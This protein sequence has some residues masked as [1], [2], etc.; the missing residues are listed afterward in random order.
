[1]LQ[2][3]LSCTDP[4]P[5]VVLVG[6]GSHAPRE[7]IMIWISMAAL[8]HRSSQTAILGTVPALG[9]G[10]PIAVSTRSLHGPVTGRSSGW[11]PTL[12]VGSFSTTDY[13]DRKP[14]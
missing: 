12:R 10:L 8:N 7:L 5:P 1:M 2:A 6:S 11:F 13:S 4:G 3:L 14:F 9:L